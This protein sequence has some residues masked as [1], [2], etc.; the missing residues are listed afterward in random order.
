MHANLVALNKL[1]E[2]R[3]F[4]VFYLRPHSG[5]AG[6]TNHLASAFLLAE[7]INH[8]ITLRKAPVLQYLFY[9]SQIGKQLER[10]F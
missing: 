6:P 1:R 5:E 4:N 2:A 7:N 9:L 3:G 10:E 8:G